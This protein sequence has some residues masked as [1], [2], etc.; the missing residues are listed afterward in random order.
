MN[1]R[2]QSLV[3]AMLLLFVMPVQ[4]QQAITFAG[5]DISG[6]AGHVSFSCGE[7]ATG[8]SVAKAITVIHITEFF[9]EGVQQG[10]VTNRTLTSAPLSCQMKAGTFTMV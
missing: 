10:F 3:L 4:A 1:N 5:G 6:D 7:I 8:N 9:T 2:L